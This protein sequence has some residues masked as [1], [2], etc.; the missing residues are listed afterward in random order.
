MEM[1]PTIDP[2]KESD[3]PIGL[4]HPDYLKK[5]ID[6]AGMEWTQSE[7]DKKWYPTTF[8]DYLKVNAIHKVD[9]Q[10]KDRSNFATYKDKSNKRSRYNGNPN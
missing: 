1:E 8:S 4:M 7:H 2:S 3:H 6:E 9:L 5:K 10:S